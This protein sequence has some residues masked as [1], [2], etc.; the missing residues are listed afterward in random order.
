VASIKEIFAKRMTPPRLEPDFQQ[1]QKQ[2]VRFFN[3]FLKL[4]RV[5]VRGQSSFSIG[6]TERHAFL[7]SF[8]M[9]KVRRPIPRVSRTPN[10]KS[11]NPG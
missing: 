7:L 6:Q 1:N 2:K 9:Q 8:L 4:V 11:E 5:S 10:L 3:T